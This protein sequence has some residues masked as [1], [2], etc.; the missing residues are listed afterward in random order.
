M[1][2]HSP[3]GVRIFLGRPDV[4]MGLELKDC[5]YSVNVIASTTECCVISYVTGVTVMDDIIYMS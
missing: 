4:V 5:A 3:W 1:V 2:A